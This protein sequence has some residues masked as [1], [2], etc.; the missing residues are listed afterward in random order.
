MSSD[1]LDHVFKTLLIGD[2]GVGKFK[3]VLSVTLPPFG[4]RG[5]IPRE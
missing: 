2:A 4:S 5:R 3:P 1:N